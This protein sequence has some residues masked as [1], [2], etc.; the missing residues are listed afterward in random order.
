MTNTLQKFSLVIVACQALCLGAAPDSAGGVDQQTIWGEL[1]D[2]QPRVVDYKPGLSL[3]VF[4]P[5]GTGAPPRP[6]A[7]FIHGGGW[8]GGDANLFALHARYYASRG[9]VGISVG[10]RLAKTD[11]TGTTPFD[12]VADVKAAIRYIRAHATELG[13][14]PHR[15]AVLGDSAGGHLAAA[16]ALLPGLDAAD[17]DRTVSARPDV[18]VLYNPVIDTT[19][20]DGWNLAVWGESVVARAA[21]LSPADHVGPDAPPTLVI[22][23]TA[24]TVVPVACSERFVAALTAAGTHARLEK[25]AGAG[26]AF[27]VPGYSDNA[28]LQRSLALTD[29]F[30]REQKILRETAHAQ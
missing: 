24:D 29:A 3:L 28:T 21:E 22:H 19:P 11:G 10:Y 16:A 25:L 4:A 17:D 1:T 12:C 23:G 27:I 13:V 30:L 20:P 14:D 7:V 18:L 9:L 2:R 26:H 5:S 8:A 6:A 15:L